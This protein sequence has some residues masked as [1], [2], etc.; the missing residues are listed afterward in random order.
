MQVAVAGLAGWK[1]AA[2]FRHSGAI[3][4]IEEACELC[5]PPAARETLLEVCAGG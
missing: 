1:S 5:L 4:E 3:W 2:Q